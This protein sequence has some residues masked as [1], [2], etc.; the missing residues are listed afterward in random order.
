MR[1][2]IVIQS[3]IYKRDPEVTPQCDHHKMALKKK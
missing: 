2:N 3:K 1:K